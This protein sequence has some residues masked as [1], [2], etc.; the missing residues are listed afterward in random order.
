MDYLRD[1]MTLKSGQSWSDEL[2]RMIEQ[3]DVFQLFWSTPASQSPYVEQ[4]W[5]HALGLSGQKGAAFIRP[6]YWERP[7]P[8]VPEPLQRIHFAPFDF[9][10][11]T[12]APKADPPAPA[13]LLPSEDGGPGLTTLT[14]STWAAADPAD[15]AGGRL[16]ARTR[17]ALNGDV[18][19]H[20]SADPAD[21]HLLDVHATL[22]AE[23]IRARRKG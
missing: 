18:E 13:R 10:G 23:A 5:R 8:K 3:A 7:L 17:I 15:P 14:V 16:K 4:E 21:A 6:I 1:V 9:P 11:L 20:L 2:L 22:V 12:V 19:S